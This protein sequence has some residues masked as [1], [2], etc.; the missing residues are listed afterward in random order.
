MFYWLT[1]NMAALGVLGAAF[2]FIWSAIQFIWLRRREQQTH[3]FEA[4]HHLIKNLVSP[5]DNTKSMWIDRQIAVVFELK[6]FP[7]YYEVTV[8]IL[9]GLREK[10][11]TEVVNTRLIEEI[12]LTLDYIHRWNHNFLQRLLILI[13]C[14]NKC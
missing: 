13:F 6:H 10:W 11:I 1:S 9:R 5:D 8:R 14:M 12:D 2:A 7:R 3:E 4:F